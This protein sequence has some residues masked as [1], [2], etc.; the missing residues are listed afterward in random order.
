MGSFTSKEELPKY[1]E[2]PTKNQAYNRHKVLN[3]I[4][5]RNKKPE[6]KIDIPL[7]SPAFYTPYKKR[8]YNKR[9]APIFFNK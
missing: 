7:Q 4:K 5:E 6:L 2:E 8:R 1:N 9:N 3:E